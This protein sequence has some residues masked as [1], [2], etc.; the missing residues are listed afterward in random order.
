MSHLRSPHISAQVTSHLCPGEEIWGLYKISGMFRKQLGACCIFVKHGR[1][2]WSD[3]LALFLHGSVAQWEERERK[4]KR[5][6]CFWRAEGSSD[7][8][9]FQSICI[10]VGSPAKA[11]QS[12]ARTRITFLSLPSSKSEKHHPAQ[13]GRERQTGHSKST[14]LGRMGERGVDLHVV[15]TGCCSL[16][17]ALWF[18]DC[19]ANI[20]QP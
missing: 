2:F 7:N 13:G 12:A 17:C 11:P 9:H 19:P 14:K 10:C 15:N 1:Y 5:F 4:K 20:S 3:I 18:R 6:V 16:P 8:E